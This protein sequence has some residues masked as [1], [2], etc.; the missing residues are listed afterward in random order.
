MPHEKAV[1]YATLYE[2]S[3]KSEPAINLQ[4]WISPDSH[5][6]FP[7]GVTEGGSLSD[8][9]YRYGLYITESPGAKAYT[10][11][12]FISSSASYYETVKDFKITN[13]ME[14]ILLSHVEK[15]KDFDGVFKPPQCY[16]ASEP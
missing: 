13:E 1:E 5:V 12:D 16:S 6:I 4:V 9:L 15:T 7:D 10:Y 2:L 14:T 8:D 3:R 11:Q